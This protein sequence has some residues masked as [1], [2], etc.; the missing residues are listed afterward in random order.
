LS[1]KLLIWLQLA[2]AAGAIVMAGARLSRYGDLIARRTGL[3][4]GWIGLV[5]LATVTS[6]PE[7]TAGASA[8]VL[9]RA[10]DIAVGNVLGAC[11]LNFAMIAVLDAIHRSGSIYSVASQGHTLG[12]G[13][14]ILMLGAAGFALLLPANEGVLVGHVSLIT[15][16]LFVLYA[17]AIRT[18]YDYERRVLAQTALPIEPA[19]ATGLGGLLWRYFAAAAVV[20]AAA[21]WLPFIA[22]ELAQ[23]MHWTEGFVGTLLVAAGTTLPELT[24]TIAAVRIG[25][26]DLAIGNLIGSVLFNLVVLGIDDLLYTPGSLYA[27][28]APTHALSVVTAAMMSGAVIVALVARHQAR[29]LNLVSW[30]SA[31]LA[32]LFFA[33]AWIHLRQS[34]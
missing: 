25:A 23:Q 20:V 18:I 21:V 32:L 8:V 34:A 7:L 5:L 33:N 2:V 28:V 6:L 30:T 12:A 29:L 17:V 24:V 15:P 3:S 4:G 31:L 26:L 11:V 27:A 1:P 22:T 9:A 14:A 10:P 16:L 19:D 13:F